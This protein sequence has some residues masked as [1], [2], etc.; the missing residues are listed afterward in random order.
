MDEGFNKGFASGIGTA[1]AIVVLVLLLIVV[2]VLAS[3]SE[4][5][6]LFSP[7]EP[8]AEEKPPST[9]PVEKEDKAEE[10]A[11]GPVGLEIVS[12]KTELLKETNRYKDY[13][14]R[15]VMRNNYHYG[16]R[17]IATVKWLDANQRE[18]HRAKRTTIV[19][20]GNKTVV[21][22][23]EERLELEAVSQIASVV[24]DLVRP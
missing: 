21:T 20:D 2:A 6:S 1:T 18:L 4:S 11:T 8:A 12:L 15:L 23:G 9:E 22:E 19:L 7:P 16:A 5:I 13:K 24:V 10:R 17:V 3:Q 14:W